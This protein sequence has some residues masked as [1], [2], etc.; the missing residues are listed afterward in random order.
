MKKI[1]FIT[2]GNLL[3]AFASAY[4]I[5]P[6]GLITGG[7]TGLGIFFNHVSGMPI[8]A[9]IYLFN[10]AMFLLGLSVLG[11]KF[12]LSTLLSS[13][14][15]PL[16][17]SLMQLLYRLTGSLTQ[18]LLLAALYAGI[19]IGLSIGLIMQQGAS[20]GGMDIPPLVLE[21][22]TGFPVS[23]SLNLFD[24]LIL[25]LQALTTDLNSI[26][27][28]ILLVI[29]Y[30]VVL[31]R[32]LVYGRQQVELRIISPKWEEINAAIL[33]EIDRGSTV[34]P[35]I[36]GFTGEH[37][38]QVTTVVSKRELFRVQQKVQSID[39]NAFMTIANVRDVRGRGFSMRKI[40]R[41][42]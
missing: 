33:S 4:F 6:C 26:M 8:T 5:L 7:T 15:Y 31:D 27:H 37:Y 9:F 25:L 22:T 42:Q 35:V 1:L 38:S 34:T 18:D 3:Y 41:K 11:K 39:K 29:T 28:G 36:G 30:T 10:A 2:L 13:F 12:A 40:Y 17:L 21:K 20:S 19:C 16:L 14:E 23:V 32:T 24:L